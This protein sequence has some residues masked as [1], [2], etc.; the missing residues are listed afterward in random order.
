MASQTDHHS[1]AEIDSPSL[2]KGEGAKNIAEIIPEGQTEKLP[3]VPEGSLKAYLAVVGAF[4]AMFVSFGFVNCIA[5]FQAEY[6][7]NQLKQYTSSQVSWITSTECKVYLQTNIRYAK[8]FSVFFML[9]I[10][11]LAGRM[12]DNYGPRLPIA[13]GTVMHVFGLMMASLSTKYY[14]FVLS[15]SVCSGIGASLIFS[16][17]MTAVSSPF[18]Y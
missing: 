5:L 3:E 8:W 13:I 7:T 1:S 15:Q 6:E 4:S 9:F 11:P 18:P 17:A 2:E 16:P 12:F 10:S 14:Q